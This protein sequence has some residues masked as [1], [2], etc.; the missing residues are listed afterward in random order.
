MNN[1]LKILIILA[2]QLDVSGKY[3]TSQAVNKLI[4][5]AV[6]YSDLTKKRFYSK[7]DKNPRYKGCHVWTGAKDTNGYGI[8]TVNGKN[9]SAHKFAWELAHKRKVPKGLVLQHVCDR[10]NCVKDSHLIPGTQKNNVEDRVKKN[11]SAKGS[12]NGRARL[13]EKN[14]IKIKTLRE[15]GYTE[16]AIADLLG[17]GRSTISHILKGET[18][19]WLSNK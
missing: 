7:V 8:L 18:W 17:V 13:T 9:Y 15:K 14:I 5:I 1:L 10:P 6:D 2:D 19:G 16:K 4:K 12:T 3:T 11:R